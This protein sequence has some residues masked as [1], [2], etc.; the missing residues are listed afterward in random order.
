MKDASIFLSTRLAWVSNENATFPGDYE[1][2]GKKETRSRV[3]M[4]DVSTICN[5]AIVSTL[6]SGFYDTSKSCEGLEAEARRRTRK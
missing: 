1:L 4:L 6:H 3:H 2:L 5:Y